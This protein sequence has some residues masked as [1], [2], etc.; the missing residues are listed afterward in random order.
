MTE[1][2]QTV[3][4]FDEEAAASFQAMLA[5]PFEE[6]LMRFAAVATE[7]DRRISGAM[8]DRM[9]NA[10]SGPE[11]RMRHLLMASL[12]LAWLCLLPVEESDGKSETWLADKVARWIYRHYA[13]QQAGPVN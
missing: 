5:M 1:P 4:G 6:L 10:S 11:A 2:N 7:E 3:P 13:N 8:I 9:Y 12:S